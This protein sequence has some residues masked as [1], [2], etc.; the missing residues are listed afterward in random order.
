MFAKLA[1]LKTPSAL[2]AL[3]LRLRWNY[4]PGAMRELIFSVLYSLSC[5][6]RTR[7]RL[8]LEIIALRH[9]LGVLQRKVPVCPRLKMTDRW[10]WVALS[11]LWS[12]WRSSL[13]IVKPG[14][15]VAWH[16]KGFRLYWTWKTRQRIGRP[17]INRE[18]R[19]IIQE[20]SRANP[21]WGAP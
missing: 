7:T 2:W 15:V 16:R 11:K 4:I 3:K 17:K 18:V 10:L 8:H 13:I 14:T 5:S 21:L 20:M 12:G 6:L 9:R 1:L 19:E